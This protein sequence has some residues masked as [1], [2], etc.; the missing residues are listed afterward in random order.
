VGSMTLTLVELEA[1]DVKCR[2]SGRSNH[3]GWADSVAKWR[4]S[5]APPIDHAT[6]ALIPQ[7]DEKPR[8][9]PVRTGRYMESIRGQSRCLHLVFAQHLPGSA[10]SSCQW[11]RGH[12]LLVVRGVQRHEDDGVTEGVGRGERLAVGRHGQAADDR[13]ALR[14]ADGQLVVIAQ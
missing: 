2:P 6:A 5:G 4:Q 9:A 7:A 11:G 13:V 14:I 8:P 3:L 1:G 10:G 12:D